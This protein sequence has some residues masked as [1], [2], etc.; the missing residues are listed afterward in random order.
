MLIDRQKAARPF[1]EML[2]TLAK[3]RSF[4]ADQFRRLRHR[5]E[6]LASSRG[7]RM[8]A[9]TSAMAS[10][11]KTLTAIN[12]AG[13]LAEGARVLLIDADLRQP[14]VGTTLGLPNGGG[15]LDAAA[16][17][18]PVSLQP[19]VQAI[20]HSTFDVLPCEKPPVDPYA[21]LTSPG[22]A[23]LAAEARRS[24]DYVLVDTAPVLP[25]PD[26]GLLMRHVDG[27]LV[28]VSANGTPRK[29]L[30][31]T[32]NQLQPSSVLGLVFNRDTEPLFGYYGSHYEGYFKEPSS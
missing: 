12:L 10:D 5:V 15:G 13:A 30:A 21:F 18:T 2:V 7:F 24:Y 32:L 8:I 27:Y 1:N 31:E 14:A 17:R 25:V 23:A 20:G 9:V 19:Y 29:L 3:P 16:R 22:F 26:T 4:E 6:E 11:G 28:V